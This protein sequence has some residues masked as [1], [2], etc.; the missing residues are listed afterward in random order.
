MSQQLLTRVGFSDVKAEDKTE[1]FV[2]MLNKEL[3]RLTGMREQFI[4]VIFISFSS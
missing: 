4:K 1:L 3:K 2:R